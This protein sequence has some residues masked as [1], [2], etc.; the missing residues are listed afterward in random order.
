MRW[1]KAAGVILAFLF[2]L[3]AACLVF[4][5]TDRLFPG[6]AVRGWV[7][8]QWFRGLCRVLGVS[9]PHPGPIMPGCPARHPPGECKSAPGGFVPEGGGEQG[10]C[11][12]HVKETGHGRLWVANHISWLDVVVLGAQTPLAFIAKSEIAAWPVVGLLARSTGVLFVERGRAVRSGKTV[13]AM[14]ERLLRGETLLLFPEGTTTRGGS[15]ARFHSSLFQAALD[16]AVPVI[17]LAVSYRGPHA[18]LV[19][20]VGD[21]AF[22]PHLWRLLGARGMEA[23]LAVTAPLAN[24]TDRETLARQTRESVRGLVLQ[25]QPAGE[26][27]PETTSSETVELRCLAT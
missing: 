23:R 24:A 8:V 3:C 11:D 4:P 12:F 1:L 2:G 5:V 26:P 21:D 18:E 19:P 15:V 14:R 9:F 10:C 17:P 20:F 13:A 16:A 7:Q 22:V 6:R 25:G 27:G